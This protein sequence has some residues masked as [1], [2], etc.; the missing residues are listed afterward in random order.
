V[1][2][3]KGIGALHGNAEFFVKE[4]SQFFKGIGQ[5]KVKSH[6]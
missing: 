4:I 2:G 5:T 3:G 6:K 1:D